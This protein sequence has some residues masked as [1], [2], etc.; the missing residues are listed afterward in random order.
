MKKL[1]WLW[2]PLMMGLAIGA[3]SA[4][5]TTVSSTGI[6]DSDGFIWNAGT[7]QISFVPNPSF[8]GIGSYVWSGGN[9]QANN[10]FTGDLNGSGAFSQSIPT[11]TAITPTG[12]S[13]KYTICPNASSG[14]FSVNIPATG[15]TQNNTATI[16]T[17]LDAMTGPRFAAN[18]TAF[19][20]GTVEV[21]P[22]PLPGAF[23]FNTTTDTCN[24][25][26][27]VAWGS[28]ATGGGGGGNTTSTSLT[29]N[30]LPKANGPNSIINSSV[31]DNGTTVSTPESIATPS[32]IF[33]GTLN[34]VI[35]ASGIDTNGNDFILDAP[36]ANV[37][38]GQ[39]DGNIVVDPGTGAFIITNTMGCLEADLITSHVTGTGTAC[40][41]TLPPSGAAGGALAGT[42]PNPTIA[43]LGTTTLIPVSDGAG[44]LVASTS[45]IDS[46]N[47]ITSP[48][49]F[50]SPATNGGSQIVGGFAGKAGNNYTN[51]NCGATSAIED[52]FT[53]DMSIVVRIAAISSCYTPAGDF[54]NQEPDS[55]VVQSVLGRDLFVRAEGPSVI[56]TCTTLCGAIY[57][58]GDGSPATASIAIKTGMSG[59]TAIR[60]PLLPGG[61]LLA[62][63]PTYKELGLATTAQQTITINSTACVLG[64]SCTVS[65]SSTAFQQNGT[66]LTSSTTVNFKN[67]TGNAGIAITNPTA[68][69]LDFNLSKPFGAGANFTTGPATATAGD[70]ATYAGA[71]GHLVDSSTLLSSLAPL[72][73]PALTGTPTAPTGTCCATSTQIATQSFVNQAIASETL[74]NGLQVIGLFTCSDVS[75][76][77]TAQT[78]TTP[79]TFTPAI[80]SCVVY[81]TNTA[82]TGTGLTLNINS[83]GAKSVAKWLGTTTLA[84][85]DV[86]ANSP[87]WACYNGTVW[88]LS[89]IGNAPSGGGTPSFTAITSG[90]NTTAAMVVGAGAS[91]NFTSTG[92]INASTLGGATF[93]S[94]GAVGSGTASTGRFTTVTGTS[95]GLNQFMGVIA[96]ADASSS[97]AGGGGF[98]ATNAS[99]NF[100][101]AL[102]VDGSN[103]SRIGPYSGTISAN[104]PLFND[105]AATSFSGQILYSGSAPTM[106]AGAAAGT[107]PTCTTITGHNQAGVISCTTGTVP[108]TGTLATITFNGTLNTAPQGCTLMPRNTLTAAAVSS[109]YTTAPSTTT[110]TIVA[111]VALTLATTYSWSYQCM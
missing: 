80:N 76:S 22:V 50:T 20:Y 32:V 54:Q 105:F 102:Y 75:G 21:S 9:L 35:N 107:A 44:N 70:I 51:S 110:W 18:P 5:S 79:Q 90:T 82:N 47:G 8:P 3:A 59:G 28:C 42:Y 52:A 36:G 91:L 14:C 106:V 46:T 73:N 108:T 97:G 104:A 84:A 25:W 95:T 12:S 2:L 64:G 7:Y 101:A 24:Q 4:Q 49:G 33:P 56:P 89:T 57:L 93:A 92:T 88:N 83:L 38:L 55:G 85:G 31:S 78:C 94:P 53:N 40:P 87:Q 98:L 26:S 74:Q 58:G 67:G 29:T 45:T 111:A 103:N 23:F 34:T 99:F 6:V 60:I 13:W 15:S 68:G 19:G 72:A 41:T 16:N 77:G 10:L 86:A 65:G 37:Y 62:A 48:F 30:T 17:V 43:G 27:G 1:A 96:V 61:G 109:V 11:S 39:G 66:P 71:D 81:T 63:D 100:G 69:E